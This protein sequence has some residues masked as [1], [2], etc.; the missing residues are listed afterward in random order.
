MAKKTTK[1]TL[2]IQETRTQQQ[3]RF[4]CVAFHFH[5]CGY[6]VNFALGGLWK[7]NWQGLGCSGYGNT[8]AY[9]YRN[10]NC[11]PPTLVPTNT[12]TEVPP[13]ATIGPTATLDGPFLYIVQPDEVCY[14]IAKKFSVEDVEDLIYVNEWPSG[15]CIISVG[16][17]IKVPPPWFRRPTSTPFPK[18]WPPGTL[19]EYYVQS[20]ATLKSVAQ[21]FNSTEERIV[22]ATNQYRQRN[23]I[24]PLLTLNSS[25]QIGELLIVPVNLVTPTPTNTPRER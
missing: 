4:L 14:D 10:S 16:Q 6:C 23:N 7:T 20:G 11:Y 19:Y 15:Q 9:Q 8:N 5:C 24:K 25:L 22:L 17:E 1:L 2:L 18:D 3:S 21:Y 13:T 12:P